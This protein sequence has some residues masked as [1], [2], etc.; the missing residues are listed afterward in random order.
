MMLIISTY[1]NFILFTF[2]ILIA[3]G[4]IALTD[5]AEAA[6]PVPASPHSAPIFSVRHSIE[7][8]LPWS[9]DIA[10]TPDPQISSTSPD[11]KRTL[12]LTMRGDLKT[13]KNHYTLW[14]YSTEELRRFAASNGK[15]DRPE[16]EV[17]YSLHTNDFAY[18]Y[19]GMFPLPIRHLRWLDQGNEFAFILA[20]EGDAG[21]VYTFHIPSRKLQRLT[22]AEG[23]V[24]DYA[25]SKENNTLVYLAS[26]S[27]DC[28][29]AFPEPEKVGKYAFP[30][31]TGMCEFS[32]MAYRF[33]RERAQLFKASL[34]SSPGS[35]NQPEPGTSI[36]DLFTYVPNSSK[37]RLSP[38]GKWATLIASS[39]TQPPLRW[40][41]Y[42]P[43]VGGRNIWSEVGGVVK[44]DT[45]VGEG[46]VMTPQFMLVDIDK[47]ITTPIL[48][49]PVAYKGLLADS[50]W[51][52]DSR[53]V[54]LTHTFLPDA[55]HPDDP[56]QSY[57][58]R[59]HFVEYDIQDRTITPFY[60]FD[61]PITY[62]GLL[63]NAVLKT[64]L[65][66]GKRLAA[67]IRDSRMRVGIDL[68]PTTGF[69]YRLFEK[70]PQ[71]WIH[72]DIK[73][74]TLV[75][76]QQE[77]VAIVVKEDLN[78]PPD[79]YIEDLRRKRVI[80][81]TDLNP[82]LRGIQLPKAQIIEWTAGDGQ[83][84]KGALLL[85][86][87]YDKSQK[88]PL[89]IQVHCLEEN[90]FFRDAS[91][92]TET[93]P[94]AGRALAGAGFA[95]LHM[96]ADP[97]ERDMNIAFDSP[98]GRA[99]FFEALQSVVQ[100]LS[101]EYSVDSQRIGIVGWSAGGRLV[102]D[103]LTT[104]DIPF[105][106][107]VISDADTQ[108]PLAYFLMAGWPVDK[109][110]SIEKSVDAYPWG[111]GKKKWIENN[112]VYRSDRINA[113]LRLESYDRQFAIVWYDIF[114]L[115]KRQNKPVEFYVYDGASHAPLNPL[116]RYASSQ[117]TVDWMRF[118][119]MGEE[120]PDPKKQTQYTSWR[121]LKDRAEQH[122]QDN[123]YISATAN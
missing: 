76:M 40:K 104:T 101:T 28:P 87:T 50:H 91:K 8:T 56:S 3:S 13:G 65:V 53:R 17:I 114:T 52:P 60:T 119:L 92:P 62:F 11:G 48:D 79:Y 102:I 71:G 85:P 75:R 113:A 68:F 7:M 43:Q 78:T 55:V 39:L 10:N 99:Q 23:P 69:H 109:A 103:A 24:L 14:M 73:R 93:A 70:T 84:W 32:G 63:D 41:K 110:A 83:K 111:D 89:V 1:R 29:V 22:Q 57:R 59:V 5:I 97:V 38:D 120:D 116:Q 98:Q 9:M 100:K 33:P 108:G 117:G 88:Y 16:G 47:G 82:Q 95:V 26:V 20:E 42:F 118:W 90:R 19:E 21:D 112:P 80:R 122:A 105:R 46:L 36:S 64:E 27:M 44:N 51:L 96:A 25:I 106:S 4:H 115:L 2:C 66:D 34:P 37:L 72:Q 107:A 6:K 123:S 81:L 61:E 67:K 121:K 31:H 18:L 15:G 30:I 86:P 45:L 94:F 54:I 12:I 74:D 49:A 77:E 35:K 58:A